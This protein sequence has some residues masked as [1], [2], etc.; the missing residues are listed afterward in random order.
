MRLV[1]LVRHGETD[2]NKEKRLQGHSQTNLNPKGRQDAK[3]KAEILSSIKFG[4]AF[5][6][7]LNRAIQTAEILCEH[8]EVESL[9]VNPLLREQCFGSLEGTLVQ[10]YHEL[11]AKQNWANLS[12]E[13]RL[14]HKATHDIESGEEIISRM[15]LFLEKEL[16]NAKFPALVVTHGSI[17]RL[18]LSK[19]TGKLLETMPNLGHIVY[20][21][22]LDAVI[23]VSGQGPPTLGP[24]Q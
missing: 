19:K 18:W 11:L 5:S 17:M 20:D 24:L 23:D 13:E 8:L 3:A 4:S 1:Y 6:S 14:L 10:D 16:Q 12:Y 7:D 2:W 9:H 21:L 22:D 15:K